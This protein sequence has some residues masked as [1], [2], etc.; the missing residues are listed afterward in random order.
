MRITAAQDQTRQPTLC[1]NGKVLMAG[2]GTGSSENNKEINKGPDT[3]KT[4]RVSHPG[5]PQYYNYQ[6]YGHIT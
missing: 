2:D 5:K 6:G 4:V 1:L 3:N